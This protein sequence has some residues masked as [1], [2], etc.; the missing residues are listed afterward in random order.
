MAKR[1]DDIRRALILAKNG[2]KVWYICTGD[3]AARDAW[4]IASDILSETMSGK[5]TVVARIH[6]RVFDFMGGGSIRFESADEPLRRKGLKLE[7]FYDEFNN[8]DQQ[9]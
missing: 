8:I 9:I 7:L 3:R 6:A 5:E 2:K 1:E 4:V